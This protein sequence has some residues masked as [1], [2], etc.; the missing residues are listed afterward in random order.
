MPKKPN[1]AAAFNPEN[2]LQP[3]T[4]NE[5]VDPEPTEKDEPKKKHIGGYFPVDVYTQMKIVCA[6]QNMTTQE[7]LR[8]GLNTQFEVYNKP[9]IA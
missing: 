9:P 2:E 5:V 7:F 1:L 3:K 6:E 8:R 4:K